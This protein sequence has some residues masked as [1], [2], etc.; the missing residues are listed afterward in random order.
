MR[1]ASESDRPGQ[2]F[3]DLQ[4]AVISLFAIASVTALLFIAWVML[5]AW[6]HSNEWTEMGP[7]YPD[8]RN[9]VS[10]QCRDDRAKEVFFYVSEDQEE[11]VCCVFKDGQYCVVAVDGRLHRRVDR[12]G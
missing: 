8:W 1:S 2:G 4:S 9:L 11:G 10:D 3:S 6:T 5:P 12:S 7:S